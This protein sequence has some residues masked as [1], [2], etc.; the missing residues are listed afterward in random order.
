VI[1]A[2]T[3]GLAE[4]S[5]GQWCDSVCGGGCLTLRMARR[6]HW[7]LGKTI[8]RPALYFYHWLMKE[9]ARNP[10]HNKVIMFVNFIVR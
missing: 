8:E 4:G 9:A 10:Q 5:P 3:V 6:Q 7:P 2:V 1:L